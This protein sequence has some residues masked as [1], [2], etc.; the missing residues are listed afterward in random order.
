M[1]GW[2]EGFDGDSGRMV[3]LSAGVGGS[4]SLKA[5]GSSAG[6]G[7]VHSPIRQCGH[8]LVLVAFTVP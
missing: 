1:L 6:A 2:S 7:G 5:V 4:Q 3:W 8:E